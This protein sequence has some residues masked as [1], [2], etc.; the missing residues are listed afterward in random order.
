MWDFS[1][2]QALALMG[3]TLPFIVFRIVVYAGIA[4]AYVLA[5]GI[6]AGI[7]WGI[8]IFGDGDFQAA[9]TVWGGVAGFGLVAGILYFA[10]EYILYIVKAGHIAVLVKLIDGEAVPDGQGQ[11][12]YASAV[13]RQRFAQS[14]VLFAVD[15]LV[16]G[17]LGAIIGIVQGVTALLPIPGLQNVVGLVRAFLRISVG[18]VDEVILAHAIRTEAINPWVSAREALVLYAQNYP[19][20]LRNAAWLTVITYLLAFVVFL[21]M[22]APAGLIVWL[23]PGGWSAG[24]FIFALVFAWAVK[25]ALIEPFAIACMMQVFFRVT[26]GQTPDPEWENRISGV[27]RKFNELKQRAIQWMGGTSAPGGEGQHGA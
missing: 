16:K 6:G 7:G 23:L 10:R 4:L 19:T 18:L 5:T 20:M 13:V 12:T 2:G 14:S 17:V 26:A 27:S 9:S 22:L 25:A 3:K 24:G 15:Q 21:V 8:G 11:I 1:V